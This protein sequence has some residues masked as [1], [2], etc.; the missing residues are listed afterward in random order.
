MSDNGEATQRLSCCAEASGDP[1]VRK[2]KPA[3]QILYLR[4]CK[5][6]LQW[7]ARVEAWRDECPLTYE[8]S[9][10]KLHPQYVIEKLREK[11]GGKKEAED[12]QKVR[13]NY[14]QDSYG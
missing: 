8:N 7:R 12:W 9:D 3:L 11:S 4:V 10:G 13:S 6:K 14:H 1:V 5:L 2:F